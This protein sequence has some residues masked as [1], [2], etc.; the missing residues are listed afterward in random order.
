MTID[1][2]AIL[3]AL[4]IDQGVV[5]SASKCSSSVLHLA[6]MPT[7]R[8]L[9]CKVSQS[10]KRDE[11]AVIEKLRELIYIAG[12]HILNSNYNLYFDFVYRWSAS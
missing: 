11:V 7:C 9:I 6:K 4:R 8:D 1:I 5:T 12:R 10:K 2:K 3:M